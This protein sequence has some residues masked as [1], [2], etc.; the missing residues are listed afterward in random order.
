MSWKL[1]LVIHDRALSEDAHNGQYVPES[2]KGKGKP[3]A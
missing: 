3:L 2:Q 1:L